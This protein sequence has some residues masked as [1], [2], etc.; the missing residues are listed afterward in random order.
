[1]PWEIFEPAAAGYD[2]WYTTPKGRRVDRGERE[3]ITWLLGQMPAAH[4]I[5]EIGCGTGH[6]THWLH[7]RGNW[8]VGL[9]RTPGMLAT[10]RNR[11]PNAPALL[12]NADSLPLRDRVVD[13]ALFVTS[14]EFLPHPRTA[15]VE[16]ARV[17]QSGLAFVVLNR[18]SLGGLSRRIGPQ[19]RQPLLGRAEDYSAAALHALVRTTLGARLRRLSFR[20]GCLPYDLWATPSRLPLGEVIGLAAVLR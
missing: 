7:A 2:R 14:L 17:A 16:A 1:M 13:V 5:L 10:M 6:F 11:W 4:R 3:L 15:I 8:V 12:G 18:W 9:D 20:S 19:A